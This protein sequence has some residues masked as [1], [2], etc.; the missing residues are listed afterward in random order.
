MRTALRNR[1]KIRERFGDTVLS[2]V[3]S[4]L[5]TWREDHHMEAPTVGGR[6]ELGRFEFEVVHIVFDVHTVALKK[7]NQ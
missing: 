6:F 1:D 2:E 5:K 7:V 4:A 3:F